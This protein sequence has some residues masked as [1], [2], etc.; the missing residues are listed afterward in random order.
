MLMAPR[1]NFR[2]SRTQDYQVSV[3][4]ELCIWDRPSK[5][6]HRI[7]FMHMWGYTNIL[8]HAFPLQSG[9]HTQIWIRG[10]RFWFTHNEGTNRAHGNL[11]KHFTQYLLQPTGY[12]VQNFVSLFYQTLSFQSLLWKWKSKSIPTMYIHPSSYQDSH[13]IRRIYTANFTIFKIATFWSYHL[14]LCEKSRSFSFTI[15]WLVVR[16]CDHRLQ[17]MHSCMQ[18]MQYA[19]GPRISIHVSKSA[20]S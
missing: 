16:M 12:F 13:D 9:A 8:E 7:W 20:R 19:R 14:H 1:E 4:P 18:R 2:G 3:M 11:W 6:Y 5:V 15:F 10:W 17:C